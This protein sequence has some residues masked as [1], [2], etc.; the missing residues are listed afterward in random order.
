M[1]KYFRISIY[2]LLLSFV[3]VAINNA[4]IITKAMAI[5]L[6][7]FYSVQ[8]VGDY[9]LFATISYFPIIFINGFVIAGL[10]KML[11]IDRPKI[12]FSFY[13]ILFNIIDYFY[14]MMIHS[15][16]PMEQ[17]L[18]IL[19]IN[20]L[21]LLA[22]LFIPKDYKSEQIGFEDPNSSNHIAYSNENSTLDENKI[23]S[24]K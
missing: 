7:I 6:Y 15:A 9:V 23:N 10:K 19:A 20:S 12:T 21:S 11:E 14:V 3:L 5:Y 22:L 16:R 18:I 24:E 8:T 13:I 17:T 2:M 4:F 1:T